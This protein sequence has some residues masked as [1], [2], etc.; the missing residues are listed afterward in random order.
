MDLVDVYAKGEIV[1][2]MTKKRPLQGE[3]GKEEY[4]SV[5]A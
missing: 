3:R 5:V 4:G 1:L 2:A